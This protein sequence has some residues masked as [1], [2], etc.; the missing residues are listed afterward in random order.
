LADQDALREELRRRL[1]EHGAAA[2]LAQLWGVSRPY[3]SQMK[4]GD[5]PITERIAAKMGF[6]K[7]VIWERSRSLSGPLSR[8]SE[9]S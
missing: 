6:R 3:L 7:R 9:G 1:V 5:K 8:A 4:N 2:E